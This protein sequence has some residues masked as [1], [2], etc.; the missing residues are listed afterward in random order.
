MFNPN[1]TA[2]VDEL[3]NFTSLVLLDIKHKNKE[4]KLFNNCDYHCFIYNFVFSI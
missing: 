4:N 3:L 1:D 2:K